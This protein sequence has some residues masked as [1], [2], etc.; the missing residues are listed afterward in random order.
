MKSQLAVYELIWHL[1]SGEIQQV[2]VLL[3]VLCLIHI[4]G[5]WQVY[6]GGEVEEVLIVI[7]I[8]LSDGAQRKTWQSFHLSSLANDL[9][10]RDD[11]ALRLGKSRHLE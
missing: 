5:L 1:R 9:V 3:D 11:D 10:I 6:F 7:D 4:Q 8:T 2:N